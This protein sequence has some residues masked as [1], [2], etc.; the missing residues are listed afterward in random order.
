MKTTIEYLQALEEELKYLPKKDIRR[1]VQ[2]YQDK[3]N[4]SLDSGEKIEK[5]LKDLPSPS[6]VAKGIY[7]GK[8]VNY[9]DKKKKE[10]HRKEVL[11]SLSCLFVGLLVVLI[12]VGLIG[13][14]SIMTFRMFEIIPKFSSKD[15]IIMTGFVVMY[16][17]SMLIILIY[18]LDVGL[19]IFNL[20]ASAP[21]SLIISSG[22]ITLPLL[23][24][25]F[26][27]S[28]PRINP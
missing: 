18:L 3:I 26:S 7:E 22:S 20:E 2:I 4:N 13:Y 19:L 6:D 25:I 10:Y 27:P 5:V 28:L 14:L 23:L 24:L 8:K 16:F 12:F 11:Q 15:K 9:L 21:N 1:V 17:I